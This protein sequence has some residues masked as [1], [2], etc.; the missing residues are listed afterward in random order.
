MAE[1]TQPRWEG[2][3]IAELKGPTPDQV[4]PFLADFCNL[5]KLLPSIDTCR[6]VEGV[7]GQ[8][9]L[10]RYC[11]STAASGDDSDPSKIKWANERLLVMDPSNKCFSYEVLDN[12]VGF[13]NYAATVR[14]MPNSDGDGKMGGCMIEWSFVSDP[15]EG[16]ELQDLSSYVDFCLQSMAKKIASAIQEGSG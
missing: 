12:N 4:W 13:K 15:V 2:K 11:A 8:P 5:H 9:G 6:Q 1:E 7:P 3:A 10:V 16:W 14:V